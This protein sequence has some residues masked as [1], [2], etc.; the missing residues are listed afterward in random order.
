MFRV[1]LCVCVCLLCVQISKKKPSPP[2]FKTLFDSLPS[3]S[4]TNYES[5][6]NK[7]KKNRK[8]LGH[9]DKEKK[10]LHTRHGFASSRQQP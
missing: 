8:C 9:A 7:T 1:I 2:F 3:I 10:N 4:H 6:E 5:N